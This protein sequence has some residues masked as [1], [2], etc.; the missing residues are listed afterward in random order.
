MPLLPTTHHLINSAALAQ[1]RPNAVLINT[2]RGGIVDEQALLAA[3][4]A[5]TIRHAILDVRETEP[6]DVNDPLLRTPHLT[7]TPHV[8][9]LTTE[10]QERTSR[11][12]VSDVLRVLAGERAIGTV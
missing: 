1:M 12:V 8:A 11:L 2:S 10:A 6:P 5:G 4:A 7:L 3:L 9:G